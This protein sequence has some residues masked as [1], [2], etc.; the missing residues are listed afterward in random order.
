MLITIS[1]A[2]LC[3]TLPKTNTAPKK[4]MV[5]PED[6]LSFWGKRS[7]F[8]GAK[9]LSHLHTDGPPAKSKRGW[10]NPQQDV[11]VG[12][13][14]SPMG[15]RGSTGFWKKPSHYPKR[16]RSHGTHQTGKPENHR[17][18]G[19]YVSSQ[20]GIPGKLLG[21]W[22]NFLLEWSLFSSF[23]EGYICISVYTTWKGSIAPL[24]CG[25]VY[26]GYE[27]STFWGWLA[28]YFHHVFLQLFESNQP[29]KHLIWLLKHM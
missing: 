4:W 10:W 29:N 17:L 16:K 9:L 14:D 20:E 11:A 21:G 22:W 24:P 26:Q 23:S 28:I 3:K 2:Q 1:T 15:A 19:L 8:S 6:L 12:R 5:F 13:S 7:F 25:L 18:V 27:K